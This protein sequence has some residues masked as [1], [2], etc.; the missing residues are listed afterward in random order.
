MSVCGGAWR[1]KWAGVSAARRWGRCAIGSRLTGVAQLG[2]G[3]RLAANSVVSW[4]I[5]GPLRIRC[6]ST[7]HD[8]AS[9]STMRMGHRSRRPGGRRVSMH[10]GSSH[11]T[12][13]KSGSRS[14]GGNITSVALTARCRL[15]RRRNVPSGSACDRRNRGLK[16][17][18]NRRGKNASFK[19]E[20]ESAQ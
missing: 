20:R 3:A 8:P 14:G 7:S 10:T 19:E 5:S 4:S 13:P 11:S 16:D 17:R 6:G 15:E 2:L 12:T 18:I 9:R 1:S